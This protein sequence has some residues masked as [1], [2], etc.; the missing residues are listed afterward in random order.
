M[1]LVLLFHYWGLL[2]D[3]RLYPKAVF[4]LARF[5]HVNCLPVA[6]FGPFRRLTAAVTVCSA[7]FLFWL[8]KFQAAVFLESWFLPFSYNFVFQMPPRRSTRSKQPSTQALES[9]G[10]SL[11]R[12]RRTA[13]PSLPSSGNDNET[14]AQSAVLL[15]GPSSH[16]SEPAIPATGPAFPP[17]LFDQ[18]VQRVAA[19]VTRQL[20]PASLLPAVQEPQVPSPPPAAFP[21][22]AGTTAVQQLTTEVPVV[23]YSPV[24]NPSAV[25]QVTQVVQSVHSSLAGESS[26]TGAS[27]PKDIFTSV[28]LPV[29]AR[30]P[31][32]LKT[33]IWNNE[34]IDFGLLLANQFAEGKYQLTINPG[35][36]SSP[37][38]ALE[39][40]TKPKKIVSIDSWVQAFHVF[41]G[42]FTSRFPSD[43]PGLMKYGSTIQ[44]LAARGHNWR[45][46]D[47]NFRFLRQTPATSLP[48]G[49][50][51]WELWLRSQSPV[52]VKKAQTPAGTGKL[53]PNLRVPRGFCFTYH[54]G[55]DCMGCSFR[56]DCFKC[57]GSHRALNCNFRAKTG[58]IQS[59]NRG[60]N[61]PSPHSTT[62]QSSSTVT[63]P[64]K[65]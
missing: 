9:L 16:A 12:R 61:K 30:V 8:F 24:G 45:F 28:N 50:I 20:Q 58:G 38:L 44:D 22:L 14:A 57:E 5:L 65:H 23:S 3:S 54:R 29:D 31:L 27:Q 64:R 32:K 41:V 36:G 47:E 13:A 40:I 34:F 56:H 51:H 6:E 39:P 11:P 26:S 52:S 46:Y 43:A 4:T 17:A 49:T 33:K 19:E 10:A 35:D 60:A 63:N 48:W 2:W 53:M 55:G 7:A 1:I 62:P 21:S 15:S 18:L 42:V 37:S 59:Q 25:D